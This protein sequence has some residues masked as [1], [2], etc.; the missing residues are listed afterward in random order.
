MAIIKRLAL[1]GIIAHAPGE[2]VSTAY[3]DQGLRWLVDPGAA[4][5]LVRYWSAVSGGHVDLAG[6][7]SLGMLIVQDAA[8]RDRLVQS[9]RQ[10]AAQTACDVVVGSGRGLQGFDG[11]IV[12]VGGRKV[13]GGATG[14]RIDRRLVP[15]ALLDEVSPHSFMAHEVGHV[16]GLD[17][18]FRPAWTNPNGLLY[19]EYGD[20]TDIM[21][22]MTFGGRPATF[23]LPYDRRSEIPQSAAVW[24][25][26]GPGVSLASVW[27]YGPTFP[28]P[29]PFVRLLPPRPA[30]TRIRLGAP[31]SSAPTKLV[32]VPFTTGAGFFTVEYRPAV[33][34]DRAAVADRMDSSGSAG[35]VVHQVR[36]VGTPSDIPVGTWPRLQRVCHE[37]T[38]PV[39]SL[40]DDD[41]DNGQVAIR[42]EETDG[43]A[44]IVLVGEALPGGHAVRLTST[45]THADPQRTVGP[46]VA[47]PLSGPSCGTDSFPSEV[48]RQRA[49]V[50]VTAATVGFDDPELLFSLNGAD[51]GGWRSLVAEAVTQAVTVPVTVEVPTGVS[52]STTTTTSVTATATVVGNALTLVL[53]AGTGTYPVNVRLRARGGGQESAAEETVVVHTLFHDLSDAAKRA[54]QECADFLVNKG[55]QRRPYEVIPDI[56]KTLVDLHGRDDWAALEA[57]VRAEAL[58]ALA[59]VRRANARLGR[60]ETGRFAERLGV[61]SSQLHNLFRKIEGPSG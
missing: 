23:A 7:V 52:T 2:Q 34:W 32:A 25:A 11:L 22:A 56:W 60:E 3:G 10:K 33:G 30:P 37:V 47:V 53:P 14:V 35:V 38:I 45:V 44:V 13:N 27:R 1:V 50:G 4:G 12:L 49:V 21:S 26:A 39:P 58:R 46:V 17:H 31:S 43:G 9:D 20:P 19:G 40:G 54:Q 24:R 57:D 61:G 42:I 6:S 29:D 48:V 5:S 51:I 36:D 8:I 59:A 15:C 55:L 28:A 16:I 41:W 18:S